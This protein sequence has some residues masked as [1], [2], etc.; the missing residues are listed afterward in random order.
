MSITHAR[1]GTKLLLLSGAG[2]LSCALI[3]AV[4]AIGIHAASTSEKFLADDAVPSLVLVAA[5][6]DDANH[7]REEQFNLV[8]ANNP[9]DVASNE[10]R[11]K[12]SAGKVASLLASYERAVDNETERGLYR[13]VVTEF[14]AYQSTVAMTLAGLTETDPS[15]RMEALRLGQTHARQ[16]YDTLGEAI[17]ALGQY[18]EGAVAAAHAKAQSANT[19]AMGLLVSIAAG[20]ALIMAVV[21]FWMN[22]SLMRQFGG[23][24]HAAAQVAQAVAQG[25]L[26]VWIALEPGDSTSVMASL[27]DMQTS[28]G[29]TVQEVRRNAENVATAAAQIAQGNNEL[30]ARTEQQASALEQTAASM[31]QLGATVRQNAENA[32]Q[33][34]ALAQSASTVAQQGGA[35][36]EEVVDTMKGI[37]DSSRKIV[38]II[39]VIDGIAFQTNI[40]A[41]NAAVEAARAGEQGRGFAVVASEVRSLAQRS[42]E[43]AK[44]IKTLIA[45]S[46]ARVEAGASLVDRAGNTM[47]EVVTSIRRVT[48]IVGE[49]SVA[50]AQQ[51]AGVAQVGEA[52]VQMDRATQQNAA[53][54]EESAAA[55]ESLKNQAL[56]LVQGVAVFKIPAASTGGRRS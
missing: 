16:A 19:Q 2:L 31:E 44:E 50:S 22:R 12:D 15:A 33:A 14:A 54:V 13:R 7:M 27:T 38:D 52:V 8:L 29:R 43:A 6:N 41:L 48:E 28:L 5:I 56:Q 53:L 49:I 30:S 40:L 9:T 46:V 10:A 39:A 51:S 1:L 24:P 4:G 36:V 34:N 42:A 37:N 11:L 25:D 45:N 20:A 55:A 26:S 47:R 23:E 18:N 21:A 35:V 32:R 17:D 3:A